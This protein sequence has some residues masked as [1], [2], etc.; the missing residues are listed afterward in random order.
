ML[1]ILIFLVFVLLVWRRRVRERRRRLAMRWQ[2]AKLATHF[3]TDYE[4]F[5]AK[6]PRRK[7]GALARKLSAHL[8]KFSGGDH[9]GDG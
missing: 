2:F 8:T 7:A 3:L 5:S 6:A 9:N 4:D 1:A